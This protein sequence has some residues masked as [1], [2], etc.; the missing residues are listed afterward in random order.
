MKR[1]FF[2]IILVFALLICLPA[3][4]TTDSNQKVYDLLTG[5]AA[6]RLDSYCIEVTVTGPNGYKATTLYTVTTDNGVRT[7]AT[8][9]EKLNGFIV[10]GE[11][12]APESYV[13]VTEG[14]LSPEESAKEAY[15]LP[16]FRFSAD[17]LKDFSVDSKTY[18]YTFTAEIT[19]EERFMARSIYGTNFTLSGVYVAGGL[20]R[21]SVSYVTENGNTVT[22]S[23]LYN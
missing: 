6:V 18:P 22:V 15:A 17:S 21:V 2:A 7:V 13:T 5:Y 4:T 9:E 12:T 11:I 20:S 8:R 14:T 23:Y 3:C 1:T 10:D 19:S 16:R